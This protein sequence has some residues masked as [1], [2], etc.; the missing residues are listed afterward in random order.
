MSLTLL[1]ACGA[2]DDDGDTTIIVN[3]TPQL[4][5]EEGPVSTS[6]DVR[7]NV[8]VNNRVKIINRAI[9]V[10]KDDL[11]VDCDVEDAEPVV[12][13]QVIYVAPNC[14]AIQNADVNNN[15]VVDRNEV[16]TQLGTPIATLEEQEGDNFNVNQ[17][18]PLSQ[19]PATA[20]KFVF[21]IYGDENQGINIPIVCMPFQVQIVETDNTDNTDNN[22]EDESTN[23]PS[24]EIQP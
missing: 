7:V 22:N 20:E 8:K 16:E 4:Q 9:K 24:E 12:H 13:Q 14:S 18:V 1:I 21:V 10:D 2:D 15:D 17:R 19:L 5:R 23:T 11:V 3:D 6:P